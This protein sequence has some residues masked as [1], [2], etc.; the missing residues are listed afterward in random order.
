MAKREPNSSKSHS[1][2]LI[3]VDLEAFDDH[4]LV[5]ITISKDHEIVRYD[6][7]RGVRFHLQDKSRYPDFEAFSFETLP[8]GDYRASFV[9]PYG[10]VTDKTHGAITDCVQGLRQLSFRAF[11]KSWIKVVKNPGTDVNANDLWD[12]L[13]ASS[14]RVDDLEEENRA[15]RLRIE[16]D[17]I[18]R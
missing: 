4:I 9:V 3:N 12:I 17:R 2:L 8:N 18:R 11:L 6:L 14:K 16:R 13:K 15:L 1:S 5:R 7:Q 10:K